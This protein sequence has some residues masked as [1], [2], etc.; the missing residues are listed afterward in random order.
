MIQGFKKMQDLKNIQDEAKIFILFIHY[1]INN[2]IKVMTKR[3]KNQE[4]KF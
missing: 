2:I 3:Y 1:Q 4:K